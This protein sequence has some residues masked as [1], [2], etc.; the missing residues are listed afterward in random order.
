MELIFCLSAI[1]ERRRTP[2]QF[3]IISFLEGH[4]FPQAISLFLVGPAQPIN[5]LK[6]GQ[7]RTSR[8]YVTKNNASVCV[9]TLYAQNDK[10]C[11]G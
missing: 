2:N 6:S 8:D 7:K 3:L 4:F 10:T 11:S 1:V 9:G 5:M